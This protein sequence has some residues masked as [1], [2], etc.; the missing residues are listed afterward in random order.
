M[1]KNDDSRAWER[2]LKVVL[3]GTAGTAVALICTAPFLF[4]ACAQNDMFPIQA[5]A[6]FCFLPVSFGFLAGTFGSGIRRPLLAVLSGAI[7]FVIVAIFLLR[8]SLRLLDTLGFGINRLGAGRVTVDLLALLSSAGALGGLCGFAGN[9]V[10]RTIPR[11]NQET[12]G[13]QF[14]IR[15]L[16][17]VFPLAALYLGLL[18]Y[19]V[20]DWRMQ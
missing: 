14:T 9:I 20:H 4:V 17:C 18:L 1:T 6:A 7:V 16:L 3:A 8:P 15:E 19:C 5:A 12:Q 10:G 2:V 11:L 13:L